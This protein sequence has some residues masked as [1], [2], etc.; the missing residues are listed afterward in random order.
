MYTELLQK[1]VNNSGW[2]NYPDLIKDKK[3]LND[4]L[5]TISNNP[6]SDQWS[7]Q[8]KIAYWINAYN[9]FTLQLIVD[10]YPVESIKDIG[11]SL[12]IPLVRTPWTK[13]FFKIG[14]K[15]TSL[16]QIEHKILRKDFDEPR[17]HFAIVC[18]SRSCAQL[19]REAY[20]ASKLDQQLTEQTRS[21][22]ADKNKN[23]ISADK[24]QISS[25]FTWFKKDFTKNGTVIQ[26]LNQYAPVKI[27]ENA[28][29]SYMDYDWKLNEQKK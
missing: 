22:L 8:E 13:R 25:Y 27:K 19:R 21:F 11:P 20:E 24:V 7:D 15:K 4:Y 26:F 10:N 29:V 14:G 3:K 18:A 16:D 1:H 9:A 2:V 12:Q 17:I 6:P 28:A 23:I 5:Q